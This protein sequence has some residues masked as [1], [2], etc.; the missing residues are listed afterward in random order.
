MEETG[1]GI[2]L[3]Q[4]STNS[5]CEVIGD[6]VVNVF[7]DIGEC[8]E[9]VFD[10]NKKNSGLFGNLFSLGKSAT[11]LTWDLGSCAVKNTPKAIATIAEVKREISDI[12][13]ETHNEIQ[14]ERLEDEFNEQIKRLELSNVKKT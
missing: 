6:D 13:V 10:E 9:T 14:N 8:F 1:Y 12:I 4:N 3:Y 5:G 11:K 2:E 7:S